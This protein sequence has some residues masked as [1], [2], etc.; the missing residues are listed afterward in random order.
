MR[1][2]IPCFVGFVASWCV[3]ATATGEELQ[4]RTTTV[5]LPSVSYNPDDGLG[6]GIFGDV[7]QRPR[8]D[9]PRPHVMGVGGTAKIRLKPDQG[10]PTWIPNTPP[11]MS[12]SGSSRWR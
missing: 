12:A 8:G 5:I 1:W 10:T 11:S 4:R 3:P 9:E 7:M 6:L 2:F